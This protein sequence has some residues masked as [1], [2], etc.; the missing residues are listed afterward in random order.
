MEIGKD[1]SHFYFSSAEKINKYQGFFLG[2]F[3]GILTLLFQRRLGIAISKRDSDLPRLSEKNRGGIGVN[4][5]RPSH[6]RCLSSIINS[7]IGY[8]AISRREI[9]KHSIKQR[10]GESIHN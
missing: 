3:Q 4:N 1:N 9:F 10:I 2:N 8:I 5:A 6:S 7:R